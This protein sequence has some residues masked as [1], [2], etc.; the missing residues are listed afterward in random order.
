MIET[1]NHPRGSH[2][3]RQ[4]GGWPSFAARTGPAKEPREIMMADDTHTITSTGNVSVNTL[5]AFLIESSS[6]TNTDNNDEGSWH[7]QRTT[8]SMDARRH[9][10]M[11]NQAVINALNQFILQAGN[12]Y[13]GKG[14]SNA[15]AA[16]LREAADHVGLSMEV[17]EALLEQTANPNAVVDYCMRSDDVFARKIKEDP[18]L[19]RILRRDRSYA[20]RDGLNL[21]NSIW[22]VFMHKVIQQ[23]LKKQHLELGDVMDKSSLTKRLYEEAFREDPKTSV[24]DENDF[25][26]ANLPRNYTEERKHVFISEEEAKRARMEAEA[27][28]DFHPRVPFDD[29]MH[30]NSFLVFPPADLPPGLRDDDLSLIPCAMERKRDGPTEKQY[31]PPRDSARR[32]SMPS[33]INRPV[34]NVTTTPKGKDSAVQRALAIF[35]KPSDSEPSAQFRERQHREP[36]RRK[37]DGHALSS[38]VLQR[39]ALFEKGSISAQSQANG[40]ALNG[41]QNEAEFSS[42]S[43]SNNNPSRASRLSASR[44]ALFSNNQASDSSNRLG[45]ANSNVPSKSPAGSHVSRLQSSRLQ[46]FSSTEKPVGWSDSTITSFSKERMKH[47]KSLGNAEARSFDIF[48]GEITSD[49]SDGKGRKSLPGHKHSK[50]SNEPSQNSQVVR[51]TSASVFSKPGIICIGEENRDSVEEVYSG[52]TQSS[53]TSDEYA[54]EQSVPSLRVRKKSGSKDGNSRSTNQSKKS[55][56]FKMGHSKG[57]VG[58]SDS[59]MSERNQGANENIQDV[60]LTPD[61]TH[62]KMPSQS[63]QQ[64]WQKAFAHRKKSGTM[65]NSTLSNDK[66][67]NISD[68][69]LHSFPTTSMVVTNATS[70]SVRNSSEMLSNVHQTMKDTSMSRVDANVHRI[71][72]DPDYEWTNFEGNSFIAAQERKMSPKCEETFSDNDRYLST[73]SSSDGNKSSTSKP[74][75]YFQKLLKNQIRPPL[76]DQDSID[77]RHSSTLSSADQYHELDPYPKNNSNTSWMREEIGNFEKTDGQGQHSTPKWGNDEGARESWVA[78]GTN[79]YAHKGQDPDHKPKDTKRGSIMSEKARENTMVGNGRKQRR[80]EEE[81]VTPM[82]QLSNT[83]EAIFFEPSRI[84]RVQDLVQKHERRS[85]K[86]TNGI[87]G[88]KKQNDNQNLPCSPT[89]PF[90]EFC[91]VDD[92]RQ[93]SS[94]DFAATRRGGKHERIKD[95]TVKIP[96]SHRNSNERR[97]SVDCIIEPNSSRYNRPDDY[98][99]DTFQSTAQQWKRGDD[100][101]GSPDG[102]LSA[103]R[104]FRQ[105]RDTLEPSLPIQR[106]NVELKKRILERNQGTYGTVEEDEID[107]L[108]DFLHDYQLPPPN[109]LECKRSTRTDSYYGNV[110]QEK[111]MQELEIKE[112]SSTLSNLLQVNTATTEEDDDVGLN[113]PHEGDWPSDRIDT[114]SREI[115]LAS[116]TA[117]RS[118][119]SADDEFDEAEIRAAAKQN[120]I[121]SPIIEILIRQSK[122]AQR[123]DPRVGQTIT[124]I[125][126]Y[127]SDTGL[128]AS[129]R[130][131]YNGSPH[132]AHGFNIGRTWDTVEEEKCEWPVTAS[133][134]VMQTTPCAN[135]EHQVQGGGILKP[136]PSPVAGLVGSR[137]STSFHTRMDPSS[138]P[139]YPATDVPEG[140]TSEDLKLLNRFIEVASGNFGGNKLSA[141]SESRVRAAAFKIGLTPKF[142]DQMLKQQS[143]HNNTKDPF[144]YERPAA[145]AVNHQPPVPVY[146]NYYGDPQQRPQT[147]HPESSS[148]QYAYGEETYVGETSTYYSADVTRTTKRTKKTQENEGCNVWESWENIRSNIGLAL[149]KACGTTTKTGGDDGSSISSAASWDE[150]EKG[151]KRVR[152]KRRSEQGTRRN[153]HFQ[154]HPQYRVANER[155][156][157]VPTPTATVA[158]RGTPDNQSMRG[159]V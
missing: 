78:F 99:Q 37:S 92:P 90:N 123:R 142:V 6:Q 116:P 30:R 43:D 2:K 115:G 127:D 139:D 86:G 38:T 155:S 119:D 69:Y 126:K 151:P 131:L 18:T 134:D 76:S 158:V 95:Q 136:D 96:H 67:L 124:G 143:E 152:R 44:L 101:V 130:H 19:S 82:A 147:F 70:S 146:H 48:N 156:F 24:M 150:N 11:E 148:G 56:D 22:R 28:M 107:S 94:Q 60:D 52:L 20:G 133:H 15:E 110:Q 74:R 68:K 50:S 5:A 40:S 17:V 159:Y 36:H 32:Q 144:T 61:V 103:L 109:Q 87:G 100:Q 157:V 84:S 62:A 120:G 113:S 75:K 77:V 89:F 106:G 7:R 108:K 141:E 118:S 14:L 65:I 58:F 111:H 12:I 91:S 137:Y 49:S 105:R 121:P 51:H 35:E 9:Q 135:L 59:D 125:A 1:P 10:Q 73:Y 55:R 16:R 42:G 27:R 102:D 72:M 97:G 3:R 33:A 128:P 4:P 154:Q 149:A 112:S 93:D 132:Q 80:E 54:E 23:F 41:W 153:S 117:Y 66:K 145:N 21:S 122:E 71:S 140:T 47:R 85:K 46:N 129:T 53:S 88:E 104:E 63:K 64:A 57:W 114:Q 83:G 25:G 138:Q 45:K 26:R 81:Q 29:L 34:K 31:V 79:H 13:K 98:G 39:R 8:S